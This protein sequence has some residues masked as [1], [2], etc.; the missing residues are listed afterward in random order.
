MDVDEIK[1]VRLEKLGRLQA[2]GGS[3]YG[4][5]FETSESI[6]AV[7][8]G[9]MEEK[10]VVLAGRI[11]AN[12][13]HGKALFIDLQDQTGKIQLY[14]KADLLPSGK[15]AVVEELDIGDIVG[16]KGGL[17]ITKTGQQ[18]VRVEDLQ[19]LSKSLMCLPE[20]WHGL[21]DVE[22]RYRQRYV[23]LIA[24][25]DVKQLFIKRSKMITYIRSFL[26]RQGFLEVE[27]PMLQPMAGGAR[28]RP[29]KSVHNAY[30][31]E[32]FLRIAPELYLKRLLV[33]GLERVYELNRNF[34]NEGISTRHNPE[35]T[36]LEVYQAFGDYQDMMKLSEDLIS[37]LAQEMTG[38]YKVMYQ[39]KEIDFTPPWERRSFAQVI[40]EKFHIDPEDDAETMLEK[41][42]EKKGDRVKIERL[43]RS[44]VMKIVEELL[45]EDEIIH[46]VFFTDYFTFL[47]PLAKTL[48][49]RPAI[50]QRFELFVAGMEVGNAYSELND[51]QEQR[52]RLTEDLDDDIE[53][54][55]RTLDED[56]IHALEY[57]MPPAGGL[58]IG[59][60][61]LVMLLTDAPSIRDVI[62]FPLLKP[63]QAD[64]PPQQ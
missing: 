5:K 54:G 27:T 23:D 51:P 1:K 29:F 34:R 36:M 64:A 41:L 42:K 44:A 48:P 46:P 49:D 56:F 47:C 24:N 20:K 30:D 26:D 4:M 39:G 21:K 59:I 38:S 32:V 3:P 53:T 43:T 17:F 50:S 61:R 19:V 62:L 15:F 9:F 22:I 40:K 13:K 11:M 14:I 31:M 55:N 2:M 60:D 6:S 37:G 25:D 58:G 18:S 16:V 57:G 45:E 10:K 52:R 8:K 28:G 63:I 7:L 12:R 33:G 35:F